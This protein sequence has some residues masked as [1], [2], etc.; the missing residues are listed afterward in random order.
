MIN[1]LRA[2]GVKGVVTWAARFAQD[3]RIA[4]DLILN[5][6]KHRNSTPTRGITIV[7]PISGGYSLS[8]TL[9]DFSFAL[10][11]VGIP[12]QTYDTQG[13]KRAL[14]R[15]YAEIL[16]PRVNFDINRYDH[17]VEM[18]KS[19]LPESVARG[20]RSR[21]VFWESESG[22]LDV[23]PY[24]VGDDTIIGM[25][26]FNVAYFRKVLPPSTS[27]RKI[28]YPLPPVKPN[29]KP[30]ADVR[31]KY[32]LRKDDFVVFYNFDL[33]AFARKN[34]DGVMRAFA[35]AF[36]HD[37]HTKLV[38]KVN[39][40]ANNPVHYEQLK[41]LAWELGITNRFM[42]IADYL[43]LDDVYALTNAC[44]VYCSLHR[45]EGFGLGVA[46]A[47][48]LGKPVVVTDWSSTTEF[49]K[50]ENSIP[51]PCRKVPVGRNDYFIPLGAWAEADV[52]A[53]SEALRQLREDPLF[54]KRIGSE[55][56]S[57]VENY[58]SAENFL[59]S[60]RKFLED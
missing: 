5:D 28:L 57:F 58:F 7:G 47:M 39:N 12:F 19:P 37:D 24:L 11:K 25:S 60:V 23:Y 14:P 35:Q 6:R 20:R 52:V 41:S 4:I 40:A 3:M 15:D 36:P 29:L 30:V 55:A 10:K 38:F 34:P 22:L 31:A 32:G 49:C 50:P 16:T 21:I 17:I 9:R 56:R 51:V 8:K 2:W 46:E 13:E 1:R 54:A 18:V 27:V 53:A 59:R 48:S 26:D 33:V 43:S 42:M 44:D 45:A